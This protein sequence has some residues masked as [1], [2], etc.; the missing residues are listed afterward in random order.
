M[1]TKIV[2]LVQKRTL[3]EQKRANIP[4]DEYLYL[5]DALD[6]ESSYLHFLIEC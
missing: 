4:E 6:R 1:M 3:L 5:L 2:E